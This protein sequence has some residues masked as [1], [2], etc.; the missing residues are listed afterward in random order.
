MLAPSEFEPDRARGYLDTATYGLPPASALEALADAA[1]GWRDR[2]SWL[3]WEDDGEAC[4]RL[5]AKLVARP[6]EDLALVPAVSVAAGL[7][8]ASLPAGPGDNVVVVAEDFASTIF[9]WVGLESRGVDVRAA[10]LAELAESADERTVLIAASYVQ[11]ADGAVADLDA[12]RATGAR[13]FIDVSQAL[14]A[15]SVDLDG[16]DYIACHTYK[17]L[18]CARGLSFLAVR[19]DRL[20]EIEPWT[21]GWKSRDSAYENYYGL[22]RDLTDDARRLDVSLAWLIAASARR[23][24]EVIDALG[25]DA[26]AEHNLRLAR[27]FARELDLPEPAS[28]IQRIMVEAPE[29][30]VGNLRNAGVACSARAGSVRMSFHLYNDDDDVVRAVGALADA[31]AHGRG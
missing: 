28:P 11:S 30:A 5:L 6:A 12:L 8:A 7:V 9:S 19:P 25:T 15:V 14:G 22:P 2:Q 27:R 21:S 10:P 29:V 13:L 4:R 20:G 31:D 16:V 1:N 26:I 18:L 17:W 23:S 3:R 24:L